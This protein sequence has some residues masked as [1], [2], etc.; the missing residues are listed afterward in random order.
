MRIEKLVLNY[1]R[2]IITCLILIGTLCLS[3]LVI[4]IMKVKHIA[5]VLMIQLCFTVILDISER[6]KTQY[7]YQQIK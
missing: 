2:I 4:K 7:Y 5:L 3:T 6:A 1:K